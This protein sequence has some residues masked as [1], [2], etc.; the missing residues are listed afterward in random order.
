MV[1]VFKD[2]TIWITGASSGIGEAVAL[3]FGRLGTRLILSSRRKEEL[4]RVAEECTKLGSECFVYPL[5]LLNSPQLEDIAGEILKKF[6]KVDILVNNG[7]IS[8]RSL[9]IDTSLEVD[10][11]IMEI[12]FFSGV[13]L[14]K[15]LL[16]AMVKNGGGHIVVISSITGLFGFPWR[17]AY[18]AAKHA[19]IGFYET[20][21]AEMHVQGIN[22]TIVCPGRIN[23]NISL[24]ALTE[25]G[26]PYGLMDHN[27]EVG[28]KAENCAKKII[29]AVKR[30]KV[31]LYIGG[32]EL[33]MVYLKRYVPFIFYKLV[34]KV[35]PK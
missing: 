23:T 35:N 32:K 3:E 11:K 26:K 14:T 19:V 24:N 5:D 22:V 8:Q 1:N 16:P 33:I 18:A 13:V 25:H 21:W 30:K 15:K 28:I 12:D 4:E 34:S 9:I 7:G 29:K 20:L 10:R 6:G 17:S 2:K 27:L 31:V